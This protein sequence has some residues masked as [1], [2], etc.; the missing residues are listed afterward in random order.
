MTTL[1]TLTGMFGSLSSS[2][3]QISYMTKLDT[4]M[5]ANMIFV[6]TT[7]LELVAAL[8]FKTYLSH[9]SKKQNQVALTSYPNLSE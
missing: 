4:W 1:L 5:V 8:V 9:Q 2:T 7:L 6:F 3:P